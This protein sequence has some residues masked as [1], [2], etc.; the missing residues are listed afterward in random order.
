[1][2]AVDAKLPGT[3]ADPR[4]SV[5]AIAADSVAHDGDEYLLRAV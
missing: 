4:R 1:M 2:G 5:L 3:F